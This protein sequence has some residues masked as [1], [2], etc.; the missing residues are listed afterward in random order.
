MDA[1]TFAVID[2]VRRSEY[3]LISGYRDAQHTLP[4]RPIVNPFTV[5]ICHRVTAE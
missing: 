5:S 4:R 3:W 1:K 2:P